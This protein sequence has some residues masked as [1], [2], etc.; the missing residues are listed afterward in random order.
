MAVIPAGSMGLTPRRVRAAPVCRLQR[1][2]KNSDPI[3]KNGAPKRAPFLLHGNMQGAIYRAPTKTGVP[4]SLTKLA[5]FLMYTG[6]FTRQKEQVSRA[7]FAV[8]FTAH[9]GISGGGRSL[10]A[11][12]LRLWRLF[13]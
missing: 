9:I 4:H 7:D 6:S 8:H 11:C 10:A 1:L 13:V 5:R 3:R 12:S 2:R